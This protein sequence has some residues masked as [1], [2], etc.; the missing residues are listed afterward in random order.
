MFQFIKAF[1]STSKQRLP[2]I[3]AMKKFL[4]VG[5]GNIGLEYAETRHNIGFKILDFLAEEENFVFESAK[6]GTVATFKYRGK[7]ILCLKPSTYM[8]L[9]GKA[10]RYW[11]E[12]EKIPLENILIVTDDINLPFGT[13]RVKTK[14]SDGGHNG[15]K[16]VQNTLQTS[17]YNRFRFGVGSEFSKGKQ[18]DYVLGKWNEDEASAL[19]ERLKKSA[20]LVRSFVFS[21]T[22]NTMNQ[23]NGT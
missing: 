9:S 3:D 18:V 1:F 5:L 4:I 20:D 15:L 14:G 2:E 22:K 16:D 7:S 19:P 13:I 8:N 12:K 11:M 6:L 10:V 17:K 21:G 23:F